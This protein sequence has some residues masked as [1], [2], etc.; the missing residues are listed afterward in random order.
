MGTG[1]LFGTADAMTTGVD[2][3]PISFTYTGDAQTLFDLWA[4]DTG[5]GTHS[6]GTTNTGLVMV[7][8]GRAK[9]HSTQTATAAFMPTLTFVT[10]GGGGGGGAVPEPNTLA[11]LGIALLGLGGFARR[12]NG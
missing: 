4:T 8:D 5:L 2:G 3:N 11:L 10:S 1:D 7:G 6:G 12:R 9:F